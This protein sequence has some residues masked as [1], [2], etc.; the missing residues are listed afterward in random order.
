MKWQVEGQIC[1]RCR[2][3]SAWLRHRHDRSPSGVPKLT[4]RSGETDA[5]TPV[6]DSS[7]HVTTAVVDVAQFAAADEP[8]DMR[9]AAHDACDAVVQHLRQVTGAHGADLVERNLHRAMAIVPGRHHAQGRLGRMEGG[10]P[11]GASSRT[12]PPV[13]PDGSHRWLHLATKPLQVLLPGQ[14]KLLTARAAITI[15]IEGAMAMISEEG[16]DWCRKIPPERAVPSV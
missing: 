9:G 7:N 11:P 1:R 16:S 8:Y 10:K 13:R 5:R 6:E 2:S 12:S 3:A 14:R 15:G 4:T